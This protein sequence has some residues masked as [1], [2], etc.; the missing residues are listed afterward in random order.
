MRFCL[1]QWKWGTDLYFKKW[2]WNL[3]NLESIL[4]FLSFLWK[5]HIKAND[6]PFTPNPSFLEILHLYP[7]CQIRGS[8][9][10]I[11]YRG[12]E[13]GDQTMR[14]NQTHITLLHK[15]EHIW[16][17]FKKLSIVKSLALQE[18]VCPF[19]KQEFLQKVS[20]AN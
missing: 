18:I 5:F 7:Y 8:Q 15:T 11:L 10:P 20:T 14:T 9:F 19:S 3:K 13:R 6:P 2:F 12:L 16:E 4:I 1:H 17:C